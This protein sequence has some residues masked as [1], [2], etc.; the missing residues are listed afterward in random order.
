MKLLLIV[1]HP[2]DETFGCGSV[3]AHA[4]ASGVES[5]VVCATRGEL[6][7]VN[8]RVARSTMDPEA[9]GV[10]R[11]AELRA[12]CAQLGVSRVDV[13]GWR[14]SG[15]VGDPAAGSLVAAPTAEVAR[16]VAQ[17]VDE[18][19]PDIL[20]VPEGSDGHRDHLAVRDAT[21]AAR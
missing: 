17:L 16:E 12:A 4:A 20:M 18:I 8:G 2:D 15:V 3:L 19:R 14:D 13:L 11:E 5:V 21:V 1:A 6:G 10:L 7:E 9:V